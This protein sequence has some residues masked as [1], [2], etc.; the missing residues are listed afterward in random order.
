V[1]TGSA[2]I[3]KQVIQ[4]SN[5][6][7]FDIRLGGIDDVSKVTKLIHNAFT[8]W[9][10]QGL[11]LGPMYQT[12]EETKKYLV[13]KGYVAENVKGEIVGTF[14]LTEGKVVRVN[15][16][17]VQFV[18]DGD[19]ILYSWIGDIE[20]PPGRL[21][22]FRKAAVNRDTANAGLGSAFYALSETFARENNYS[23]MVLETVK[24][25]GWLYDW[26]RNLGFYP[27]GSYRPLGAQVD[28]VLMIKPFNSNE[29]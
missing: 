6:S 16:N 9:R 8:I 1:S 2:Q 25:A 3:R 27:V 29:K 28:T 4:L 24:E 5:G 23:G 11:L 10:E 19:S 22:M 14:S 20:F 17:N 15:Q 18:G 12:D 7:N 26:Y 21:L 13:G